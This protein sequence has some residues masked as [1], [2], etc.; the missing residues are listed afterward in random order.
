L[1][2]F[3]KT[4]ILILE[5][6]T[7]GIPFFHIAFMVKLA[8]QLGFMTD[9]TINSP[10]YDFKEN[11][12]TDVKPAHEYYLKKE[13]HNILISLLEKPYNELNDITLNTNQRN[14]LLELIV[15]LFELHLLN[16]NTLKSY[17]VLK[18]VFSE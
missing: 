1:Y 8:K 16:I 9:E 5:E 3:I 6:V 13:E 18:E 2:D 10:Y 14:A 15:K 12:V 4:S 7:T 11:H 17:A